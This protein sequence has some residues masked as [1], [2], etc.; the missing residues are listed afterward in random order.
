MI[1]VVAG[2][3]A[4]LLWGSADYLGG[5]ASRRMGFVTAVA[6]SQVAGLAVI[7]PLASVAADVPVGAALVVAG[8]AGVAQALGVAALYRALVQGAMSLAA[9]ISAAGALL[10][11]AVGVRSGE[12]P[13][14]IVAAGA[15]AALAGMILVSTAGA[16]GARAGIVS[17][18]LAAVGFGAYWTM[19]GSAPDGTALW[20]VAI[21]RVVSSVLVVGVFVASATRRGE[22]PG[23]RAASVAVV[24]GVVD[25]LGAPPSRS[26]PRRAIWRWRRPSR[27]STRP[28]RPGWPRRRSE[29]DWDARRRSARPRSSSVS[30]SWPA[31]DETTAATPGGQTRRPGFA[32]AGQRDRARAD[33]VSSHDAA[34]SAKRPLASRRRTTPPLPRERRDVSV[35]RRAC[36]DTHARAPA[37]GVG[38]PGLTAHVGR[39]APRPG[40]GASNTGVGGVLGRRRHRHS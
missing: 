11:I 38:R 17:A 28:S 23:P 14:W 13:G 5:R 7:V 33:L 25:V 39:M 35:A 1:G 2:A 27:R 12:R 18:G 16:S 21:A 32:R 9:P 10:P 20:S 22:R 36:L 3:L 8:L 31:G 34:R 37:H 24:A 26:R 29:S 40:R 4:G 19:I 6:I 30:S 15:L